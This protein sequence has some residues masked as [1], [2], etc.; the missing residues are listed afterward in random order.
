MDTDK[1]V[2]G[3]Y[4]TVPDE[5]TGRAIA[6]ELVGRRLAACA[7]I[8][9]GVSSIYA[10]N[11]TIASETEVV[12]WFK[13]TEARREELIAAVRELHPYD[14]PCLVAYPAAGGLPEYLD[15]VRTESAKP[16]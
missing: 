2:L 4:M 7:N 3:A 13:T 5:E 9:P 11:G 14:V 12:V 16:G 8:F 1:A 10:W 15:W 6:H